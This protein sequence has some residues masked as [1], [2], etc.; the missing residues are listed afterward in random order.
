MQNIFAENIKHEYMCPICK[1]VLDQ[2]VQTKCQAPHIF[3]AGCLSFAFEMCGPQCPVCR[4]VIDDPKMS[5]EPAPL[6]LR[7]II[8][9]LDF[10]C[11]TCTKII[12]LHQ[13]PKHQEGCVPG[14]TVNLVVAPTTQSDPVPIENPA[15]LPTPPAPGPATMPDPATPLPAAGPAPLPTLP[16]PGLPTTFGQL[17]VQQ[18]LHSS[19]EDYSAVKEEVGLFIIRQ[20]LKQS[21]DGAT[22]LL[23]TGGQ[24]HII[25]SSK[26]VIVAFMLKVLN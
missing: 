7:T 23:K 10:C 9:E 11:P 24:V 20:F 17:T 6:V 15:I 14:P 22:V 21:Q 26:I 25:F 2:P 8:S 16:V 3:C 1:E 18:L 13:L 19:A 12:K 4:S 5:I